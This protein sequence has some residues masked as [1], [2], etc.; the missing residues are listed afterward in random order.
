MSSSG[1]LRS[2][3]Q[4]RARGR[5]RRAV[6][7]PVVGLAVAALTGSALA[8]C[9]TAGASTGRVTLNFYF[10]PD[11]S[12]ATQDGINNCNAHNGGKYTISYQKLPQAADGQ[13]QQMVR[14]LAAHD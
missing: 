5:P 10:Y 1:R 13:R 9:G 11:S 7:R 2:T 6:W 4:R 12:P 14:R 8:A 3:S